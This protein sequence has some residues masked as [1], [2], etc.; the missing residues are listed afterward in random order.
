MPYN[1]LNTEKFIKMSIK[2]HDNKYDYSLVKYINNTTK[3]KI[4]CPEHGEFKQ[5]PKNHSKGSGCQECGKIKCRTS[6]KITINEFVIK[7][8]KIH[9]NKYDYSNTII[10]G[11]KNKV[12]IICPEHGKFNQE[13][14]KHMSG[15]G[16]KRCTIVNNP[17]FI[18]MNNEEFISKSIETHGDV[19]N[20]SASK[21]NGSKK[22]VDVI[23]KK[24]GKFKQL[25]GVHMTGHGCPSCSQSKGEK[26]ISKI[27]K[28]LNINFISQKKFKKC[29]NDKTGRLLKF[30]FYVPSKKLLIEYD[31][32]QHFKPIEFF[33]GIKG[34]ENRQN[35]DEI[36]NRYAND[37][38]FKLLRIPFYEKK[39]ISNIILQNVEVN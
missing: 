25:A 1:K 36:K 33:G 21:Y 38:G 7:S 17:H 5:I 6:K 12:K 2:I 19:Y 15:H 22:L 24:H 28:K 34:L 32:K 23:C 8:N 27:L 16:C 20:Y 39:N 14:Y 10:D 29:L 37:N 11:V 35:L 9:K 31:G 26:E 4:I 30:D 13:A 18:K 3:I